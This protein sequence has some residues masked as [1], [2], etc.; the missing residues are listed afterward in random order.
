MS[1]RDRLRGFL[2]LTRPGNAV[3]AG[4]LTFTGA[5]VAGNALSL[6]F[7]V[8]AAVVATVCATGAGNAVNDYFDRDIDRVNRPGRPIPRGAVSPRGALAFSG[9]LFAVAVVAALTLPLAALVIAVVNSLALIAYTEFFKGL[10]GVGNVVVAYLTG[11]TFLFGGASVGR[12][13]SSSVLVL[14]F[15]AAV[16]TLT[17]EI[18]KDVEDVEGDRAEGLRTLPIVVGERTALRL[19]T[20]A[21]VVAV[22]ASGLPVLVGNFGLA[23]LALVVPADAL[24]LRASY[25][26]YDDP[27]AGQRGLKH[28]MF[29]AAAAFVVGRTATLIA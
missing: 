7:A 17:R 5:F 28:G 20:A 21:L 1:V 29:V 24:M 2:E 19:G 22:L 23:Y 3:A 10:P 4:V 6:P 25:R 11:S 26:S 9:L 8:A 16:A 14:F 18:V 27:S 15:L 12:P 13:L